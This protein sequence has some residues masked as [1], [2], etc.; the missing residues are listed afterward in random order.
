MNDFDDR[1]ASSVA[2]TA[3]FDAADVADRVARRRR[4]RRAVG[5][6]AVALVAVIGVGAAVALTGDD[7]PDVEAVDDPP[8]TTSSVPDAPVELVPA[9]E[10]PVGADGVTATMSDFHVETTETFGFVECGVNGEPGPPT[11]ERAAEL[12]AVIE[13]LRDAGLHDQ[14]F[15]GSSGG[16]QSIWGVPSVGLSS[17]YE[18]TLRWLA[19]R[20]DPADVC[21]EFPA[22]GLRNLPP[23]LAEVEVELVD[24]RVVVRAVGCEP[25][26]EWVEPFIRQDDDTAALGIAVGRGQTEFTDDCPAPTTYEFDA[27]G[28]GDPEIAAEPGTLFFDDPVGIGTTADFTFDPV[29]VASESTMGDDVIFQHAD[30]PTVQFQVSDVF[31]T[32]PVAGTVGEV[33]TD[34]WPVTGAGTIVVPEGVPAGTYFAR[35]VANPEL[36]GTLEVTG[37][38]DEGDGD[39]ESSMGPEWGWLI[40]DLDGDGADDVV[41]GRNGQVFLTFLDGV[42]PL[43]DPRG[44]LV[45][46]PVDGDHVFTCNPDGDLYDQWDAPI[47]DE[48][49]SRRLTALRV[50]DAVAEWV[51]SPSFVFE[52]GEAPLPPRGQGCETF[53]THPQPAVAGPV[54]DGDVSDV[55]VE[56]TDMVFPDCPATLDPAAT[57]P[58]RS[59]ELEALRIRL[60]ADGLTDAT[61]FY[62]GSSINGGRLQIGLYRRYQPT[63]D[64]LADR[65]EPDDICF[66]LLPPVGAFTAPPGTLEWTVDESTIDG[67]DDT[68]FTVVNAAQCGVIYEERLLPPQVVESDDRVEIAVPLLPRFGPSILPCFEPDR[69]EITLA[70]PIGDRD[71]VPLVGPTIRLSSDMAVI[72]VDTPLTVAFDPA[73]LGGATTMGDDV[74]L[75]S[76]D[77]PSVQI[78][79]GG[80]FTDSPTTG[81]P[82]PIVTDRWDATGEASLVIQ[83][84][85][86]PGE[87]TFVFIEHPQF[88]GTV[89]VPVL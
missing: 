24:G 84:D 43:E 8:S 37:P 59:A 41:D 22:F 83:S 35:L 74:M 10:D 73:G 54:A 42:A 75:Q 56:A 55:H 5:A 27:A 66:F 34:Q 63:I 9:V 47:D 7:E 76:V 21:L 19:D 44:D 49:F 52:I 48:R 80:V 2:A 13:N 4:R 25:K 20:V 3:S 6:A 85:T 78:Q 30:D 11:G 36:N 29:N 64:F 33:A 61:M 53:G 50:V 79:I 40:P 45:S 26:G 88:W 81:A 32:T 69:F 62:S 70:A 23:E 86:P 16:P 60:N 51:P 68:V 31:S 46:V 1:I 14:P 12:E 58:Q 17:R 87:Y 57:T 67:P 72:S 65:A 15:V 38:V 28:A 77:D 82:A 89:T 71:I 18:P 39:G